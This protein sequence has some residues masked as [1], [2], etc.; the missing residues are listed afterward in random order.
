MTNTKK[1][2][3]EKTTVEVSAKD[4][5]IIARQSKIYELILATN[6]ANNQIAKLEAEIAQLKQQ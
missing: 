5:E 2:T 4:F 3:E 6:A 1:T